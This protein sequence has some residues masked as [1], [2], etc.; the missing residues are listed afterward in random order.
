VRWALVLAALVGLLASRAHAEP[1]PD[2]FAL[3]VGSNLGDAHASILRHAEDDA[4][5]VARTLRLLGNFPADQ[6]VLMTGAT[7]PEVRDALIRLNARVRSRRAAVLVVYYSGHADAEALQ[8]SGTRLGLAELKALL[9]GSPAWSRVL[10]VD[11]C[12]SGSLIQ[13]KGAHPV[14]PFDVPA[15][16]VPI[17]EPVPE[18]FA[19]LTSSAASEDSQESLAL[20]SSFFTYYVNSGLMGAADEDHDGSVTLSE[21]YAF[22]SSQ[23]RAAT[24]STVAGPQNPTFQ[25]ALGGRHDL[26]LTTPGRRDARVGTLRFG[27]PGRYLVQRRDPAGLSP[28]LAEVAARE[29]G[30]QLALPPGRYRITLRGERDLAER[31][32]L[33]TGGE[34][35]DIE[36]ARMV[37]VDLGRVVRKG[38]PR[39]SATG[40]AVAGGWHSAELGGA[41]LSLGAGPNLLVA[42]RHDRRWFSLEGRLHLDQGTVVDARGIGFHNRGLTPSVAALFPVDWRTVTFALGLEL[43]PALVHQRLYLTE[44]HSAR[45]AAPAQAALLPGGWSAGFQGGLLAQ[46]DLPVGP[47]SYLRAEAGLALRSFAGPPA[48]DVH[49]GVHVR[50]LAGAGATF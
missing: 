46:V 16:L 31:E 37:R 24:A 26:V 10:I 40:F 42:L 1:D 50:I 32:C 9:V 25:F 11:A 13:L 2:R 12:R 8:L 36:I 43:G 34:T 48:S 49:R 21:L 29:P 19:V 38:G 27:Q 3:L 23:T 15:N 30:M 7:A 4:A 17:S 14:A 44:G 5:G 28:P 33:V 18:G 6:V 20:G 45:Q 47:G 41:S 39:R 22:A 35:T